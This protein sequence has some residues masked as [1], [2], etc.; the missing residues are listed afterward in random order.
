MKL[1]LSE[2]SEVIQYKSWRHKNGSVKFPMRKCLRA[3]SA[4]C[5]NTNTVLD[6][7]MKMM[8]RSSKAVTGPGIHTATVRVKSN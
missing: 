4:M 6:F 1:N 8:E 7:S 5:T 3:R 2:M